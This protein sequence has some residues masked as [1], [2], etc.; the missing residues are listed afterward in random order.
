MGPQQEYKISLSITGM[1]LNEDFLEGLA[2][3]V[4]DRLASAVSF[5]SGGDLISRLDADFKFSVSGVDELIASV[6]ADVVRFFKKIIILADGASAGIIHVTVHQG[7]E[8]YYDKAIPAFLKKVSDYRLKKIARTLIKGAVGCV[9]ALVLSGCG[10]GQSIVVDH[11]S[12]TL[13]PSSGDARPA[14]NIDPVLYDVVLDFMDDASDR[15]VNTDFRHELR[16]LKFEKFSA[17]D[18]WG[19]QKLG[20]CTRFTYSSEKTGKSWAEIRIAFPED[21]YFRSD[22][23]DRE[24]NSIL[25]YVTYHELGHCLLELDHRGGDENSYAPAQAEAM[26]KIMSPTFDPWSVGAG[27]IEAKWEGMVDHLFSSKKK[28]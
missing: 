6:E 2:M 4:S 15:G 9:T 20:L 23:D 24:S 22:V 7:E 8:V 25:K 3:E 13:R 18:V 21:W 28:I 14:P 27:E 17:S 26:P 1:R 11:T 10:V 5:G 12:P 16:I 19:S